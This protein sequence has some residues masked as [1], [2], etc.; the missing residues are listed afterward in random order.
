MMNS[1]AFLET[2]LLM[3]AQRW[4]MQKQGIKG[5]RVVVL[6]LNNSE[7]EN[8]AGLRRI[9]PGINYEMFDNLRGFSVPGLF[10]LTMSIQ[11]GA[12]SRDTEVVES[13]KPKGTVVR[14]TS[15]VG[16]SSAPGVPLPTPSGSVSGLPSSDI[17]FDLSEY[18]PFVPGKAEPDSYYQPASRSVIGLAVSATRYSMEQEDDPGVLNQGAS[19]VFIQPFKTPSENQL[20]FEVIEIKADYDVFEKL[21]EK[22]IPGEYRFTCA[23]SSRTLRR[24]GRTPKKHTPSLFISEV[25]G[26]NTL[27]Q[28]RLRSVFAQS[29]KPAS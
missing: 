13:I 4:H 27:T 24:V 3:S 26:K 21:Q 6:A 5:G 25:Q 9:V 23:L 7:D 19:V 15:S 12:E 28:D 2:G 18:I 1:M 22:G 14:V 11:Q 20:G 16:S 29:L 8:L 17:G 10:E